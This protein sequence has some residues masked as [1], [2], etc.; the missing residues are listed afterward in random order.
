MSIFND[1]NDKKAMDIVASLF[2]DRKVIGIDCSKII[3]GG[4]AIHCMTMQEYFKR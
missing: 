1:P 2:P 3:Y 4:G